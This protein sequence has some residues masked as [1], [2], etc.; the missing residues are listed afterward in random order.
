MRNLKR[1]KIPILAFI[2]IVF[3]VGFCVL[4]F[5]VYEFLILLYTE[6]LIVIDIIGNYLHE[7]SKG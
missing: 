1:G 3:I 6:A 5:F 2:V 4:A 7:I